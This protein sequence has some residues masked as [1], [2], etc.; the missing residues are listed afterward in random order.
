MKVKWL[1]DFRNYKG[2][3]TAQMAKKLKISKS[4]YEK[5]EFDYRQPSRNFLERFKK[6]F[7]D[8]DMNIFLPTNYTL[9]V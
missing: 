9:R 5:V 7:P 8:F 4:W 1:K 6:T 3:T 2:L